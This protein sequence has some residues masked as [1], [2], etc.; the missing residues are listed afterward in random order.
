MFVNSS[1]GKKKRAQAYEDIRNGDVK[2][3]Y[4]SPEGLMSE[5]NGIR[6]LLQV[7]FEEGKIA[8]WAVDEA[9]CISQW[10]HDFRPK[11][12]DIGKFLSQQFPA[13]AFNSWSCGKKNNSLS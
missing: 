5:G 8:L 3:L 12:K 13:H 10:G 1:L 6:P 9:H 7:L 11:Y 2:L 4:M